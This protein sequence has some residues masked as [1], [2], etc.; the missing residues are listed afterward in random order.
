MPPPDCTLTD[1]DVWHPLILD[2]G[3]DY[4]I[5]M[6]DVD[7]E[8]QGETRARDRERPTERTSDRESVW[9][10]DLLYDTE[11]DAG[12]VKAGGRCLALVGIE[13]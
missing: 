9:C 6:D 10:A 7:K 5:K 1:K 8:T 4:C 13:V 2:W 11:T 3:D 12:R